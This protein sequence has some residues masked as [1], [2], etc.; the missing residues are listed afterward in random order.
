[1]TKQVDD[2]ITY[3]GD[4]YT[5][6]NRLYTSL[7]KPENFGMVAKNGGTA[8]AQG[9]CAH[10]VIE[11]NKLYVENFSLQSIDDNYLP[12]NGQ[13]PVPDELGRKLYHYRDLRFPIHANGNLWI[14]QE[15]VT[16]R[17]LWP[18]SYKYVKG[19]HFED[20]ELVKEIDYSREA[21]KLRFMLFWKKLFSDIS[22]EDE[23]KFIKKYIPLSDYGYDK[24]VQTVIDG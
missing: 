17:N 11:N 6:C 24:I 16:F 4:L 7:A 8:L 5:L 18:I 20:G 3:R 19:L 2:T 13:Q 15:H 12:I 9:Y 21:K 22:F 23:Y 14:G 1:M 10:Y